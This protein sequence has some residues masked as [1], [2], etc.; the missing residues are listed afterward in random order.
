MVLHFS[1]QV[2]KL[3]I[4]GELHSLQIGCFLNLL[5]H[6]VVRCHCHWN[7]FKLNKISWAKRS[8]SVHLVYWQKQRKLRRSSQSSRIKWLHNFS[9]FNVVSHLRRELAGTMYVVR[10]TMTLYMLGSLALSCDIITS[11][12]SFQKPLKLS[13]R[14]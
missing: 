13:R 14:K 7:P 10:V 1:S 12:S 5:S 3:P 6:H 4:M 8:Q 9:N 11:S 2:L